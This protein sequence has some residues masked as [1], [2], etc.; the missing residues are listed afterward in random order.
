MKTRKYRPRDPL[1]KDFI[2]CAQCT[3]YFDTIEAF[4]AHREDESCSAISTTPPVIRTPRPSMP[5][6]TRVQRRERMVIKGA[7][8][9]RHLT[10]K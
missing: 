7:I 1:P 5:Q 10:R 8:D 4:D 3:H 6:P 2:Q 9:L